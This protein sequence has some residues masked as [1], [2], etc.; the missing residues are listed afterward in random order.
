[1]DQPIGRSVE[2]GYVVC[3]VPP[4]RGPILRSGNGGPINHDISSKGRQS[5]HRTQIHRKT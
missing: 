5:V 1:M 4:P 2:E 3:R